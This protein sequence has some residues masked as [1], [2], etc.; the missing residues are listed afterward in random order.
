LAALLVV[1]LAAS[2]LQAQ[3]HIPEHRPLVL[4]GARIISAETE[5]HLTDALVGFRQTQHREVSVVTVPDLQGYGIDDY[6]RAL[7]AAAGLDDSRNDDGAVLLVAPNDLYARIEVGSAVKPVLPDDLARDLVQTWVVPSF[8]RGDMDK[9]VLDGAGAILAHLEL[10][11]EQAAALAEQARLEAQ[12]DDSEGF[13]W[14]GLAALLLIAFLWSFLRR[15][16][17]LVGLA[18]GPISL[19][20][21]G[22]GSSGGGFGGFAGGG[23]GF[24][25]GGA[26]G[27]W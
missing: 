21:G 7:R 1:A 16:G 10:P 26:G 17:G 6:T 27:R 19:L 11:P 20:G 12:S 4:D 14:A 18:S 3:P 24:N 9:G 23:G 2:P 13:P 5:Q 25:G 15:A 8:Q 22:S